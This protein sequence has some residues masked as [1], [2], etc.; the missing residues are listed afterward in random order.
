M[1]IDWGWH[2]KQLNWSRLYYHTNKRIFFGVE[3]F[4]GQPQGPNFPSPQ[5]TMLT[6][7][8]D[9]STAA[10]ITPQESFIHLKTGWV[11]DAW[12][13]WLHENWYFHLDIIYWLNKRNI[14][15]I[16]LDP[17]FILSILHILNK[18]RTFFANSFPILPI[19]LKVRLSALNL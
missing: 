11:Q 14:V 4:W 5:A 7:G 16:F 19:V 18:M 2:I 3:E 9:C 8:L 15:N 12:L 6:L 1:C 17:D 13:Q 10:L